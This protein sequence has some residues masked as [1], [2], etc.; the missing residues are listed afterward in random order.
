MSCSPPLRMAEEGNF[1]ESDEDDDDWTLPEP[2]SNSS[3]LEG[4][5]LSALR[6]PKLRK[7]S[8]ESCLFCGKSGNLDGQPLLRFLDR[9]WKTLHETSNVRRDSTFFFLLEEN[10]VGED[11]ML[12]PH[13]GV[14]HK[15]CYTAYTSKRNL[16][17]VMKADANH[18][19]HLLVFPLIKKTA[20]QH[21]S[22]CYAAM[23]TQ[24]II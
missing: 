16:V 21:L 18:N 23:S 8:W 20:A 11:A 2:S 3:T 12:R 24:L 15:T 13:R 4:F 7:L 17:S 6:P 22:R 1:S 10:T 5:D 14:Y 9:S 19:L